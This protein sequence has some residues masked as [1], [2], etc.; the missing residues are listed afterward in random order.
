MDIGHLKQDLAERPRR[1][2]VMKRRCLVLGLLGAVL[3]SAPVKAAEGTEPETMTIITSS[4][5]GVFYLY[6]H[7]LAILLTKYVGVTFTDQATQGSNQNALLL[8]QR[9]AMI[10]LMSMGTALQGWNG[11]DWAKGTQ[12]RS[13]RALFPMF[14]NPFQFFAPKHF[15]MGSLSAFAGKRIG[16]GP[17]GGPAGTYFPEIFKALGTPAVLRYGALEDLFRD[18]A[19]GGLDGIATIIGVPTPDVAAL[20]AKEPLDFFPLS[21]EQAALVRTRFP[22]LTPSLIPSGTY[23]SLDED[24]HTISYYNFVVIHSD[25]SDDLAYRIVKAVFEHQ[26]EFVSAQPA[27]KDTVPANLD[28][29]TF[30]PLHPGAARYYR[31][32]GVAIPPAIEPIP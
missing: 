32:I 8:E 29:D 18:V 19:S 3:L 20:D 9:K 21:P 15:N 23:P 13:I 14:D 26:P 24:I 10:G 30:L 17:K 25:V 1:G 12:Y 31:E 5:G 11:T 27:A 16:T 6:G 2:E 7:A 4:P 22:E 28:R